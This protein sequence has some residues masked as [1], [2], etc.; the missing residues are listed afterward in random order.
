LA[1][2]GWGDSARVLT[3]RRLAATS[4]ADPRYPE[5]LYTVALVA[6][7][8]QDRRL[9]LERLAVEFSLS[10]WADDALLQLAQLDYA[11]RNAAGAVDQIQRLLSD[12]PGTPL[13]PVAALWGARAA[14][15]QRDHAL[16]CRWV[17]VGLAAV[18]EDVETRNQ[19]EFQQQ[20]CQALVAA[21]SAAAAKAAPPP[22]PPPPPPSPSHAWQ[23]QVAAFRTV[24]ETESTLERLKQL[25][26]PKSIIQ[27]KGWYKVRAGPFANR[28]QAQQALNR[29]KRALGVEPF[30]VPPR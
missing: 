30:L 8:T 5:I 11:E 10:D 4:T 18:G 29:I 13:R 12:Y 25:D 22:P 3:A 24:A 6:A 21:D 20:R 1:Q 23:V 19:L 7:N 14:L 15:E 26:V 16:A 17:D 2:E 27:E 9:H 28:E